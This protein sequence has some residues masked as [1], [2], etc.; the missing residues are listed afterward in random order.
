MVPRSLGPRLWVSLAIVPVNTGKAGL[1]HEKRGL[2]DC[3]ESREL[4]RLCMKPPVPACVACPLPVLLND[5]GAHMVPKEQFHRVSLYLLACQHAKPKGGTHN[6]C[7]SLDISGSLLTMH[8]ARGRL[9]SRELS[10]PYLVQNRLRKSQKQIPRWEDSWLLLAA[11][12][13]IWQFKVNET[14]QDPV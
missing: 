7:L 13:G 6:N 4:V 5:V 8:V 3:D 9:C 10:R 2:G 1:R 12:P 14:T 11:F